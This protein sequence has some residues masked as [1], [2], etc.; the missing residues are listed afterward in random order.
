MK[1]ELFAAP[2]SSQSASFVSRSN[3]EKSSKGNDK[4]IV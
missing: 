2:G 4:V 1:F 3:K